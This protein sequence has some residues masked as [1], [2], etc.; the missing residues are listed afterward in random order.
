MLLV[1]E[2]TCSFTIDDQ[3]RHSL[4]LKARLEQ[5]MG[6]IHRY[7]QRRPG[8]HPQSSCKGNTGGAVLKTLPRQDGMDSTGTRF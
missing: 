1:R 6:R 7:G 3:L 4:E 5:R 8:Y 2:L